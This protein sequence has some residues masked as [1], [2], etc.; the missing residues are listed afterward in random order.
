MTETPA[1]KMQKKDAKFDL[2]LYLEKVYNTFAHS[3][4]MRHCHFG[5][6]EQL[7][8]LKV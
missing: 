8:S 2:E 5:M 4:K 3:L 1:W 6:K 7:I